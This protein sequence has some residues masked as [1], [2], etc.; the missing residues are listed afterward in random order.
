MGIIKIAKDQLSRILLGKNAVP[1]GLVEL[2]RY[3]RIYGPI[4][5]KQ[6]KE[7]GTVVAVSTNFQYGSIITH[8]RDSK[9]LDSN[10]KDAIL[11][12]FEIPSSYAKEAGIRRAD[13]DSEFAYALA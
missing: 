11:T 10:I 2:N 3:F 4:H 6:H 5:F 7:D 12:S 8:G 13:E 9:E 1:R